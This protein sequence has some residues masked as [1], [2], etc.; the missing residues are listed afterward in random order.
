MVGLAIIPFASLRQAFLRTGSERLRPSY[1]IKPINKLELWLGRSAPETPI[2]N[3][4]WQPPD[5]QLV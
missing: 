4:T 5:L 1:L 2:L 3:G